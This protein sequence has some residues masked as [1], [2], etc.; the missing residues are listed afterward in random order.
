MAR[1]APQD[2]KVSSPPATARPVLGALLLRPRSIEIGR[3]ESRALHFAGD[4]RHEARM[5]GYSGAIDRP[6]TQPGPTTQPDRYPAQSC[7]VNIL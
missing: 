7:Y 5:N 1:A 6:H 3:S 4:I 2:Q